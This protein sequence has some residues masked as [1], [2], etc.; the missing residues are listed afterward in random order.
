M[1]IR[2]PA[3]WERQSA[4]LL[5]WPHPD[6]DWSTLLHEV[7]PVFVEITRHASRH[8]TVIIACHND[9]HLHHI[10]ELLAGQSVPANRYRLFI[11]PSND[12]WA[13]DHGPVSVLINHRPQLL[14]FIFNG[15][16]GKFTADLDNRITTL[17][18]EA[19]A[20][21]DTPL[22]TI[23]LV[24]EGGS[25]E[26]DGS[27]TLL[28]TTSCLL[29]PRRNRGLSRSAIEDRLR[30]HLGVQRILWLEHGHLR[31]DDTDGH[32]DTLARFADPETMLYVSSTDPAD[33]NHDS[34]R[35]MAEELMKMVQSNGNPYRLMPL[36]SPVLRDSGGKYLPASYA[37]FVILNDAV[38]VPTYGIDMDGKALEI[39]RRCF[40]GRN[41]T[42]INCRPLIQQYGSLHCVT[43]QLPA[44]IVP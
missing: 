41:I 33:P 27:G 44:G 10:R 36:P 14:N 12:S 1:T 30:Q 38:L 8:Q 26:S 35:H 43:M 25:I 7:E 9:R 34:L 19:G 42:G 20:F 23:D 16:G 37:N 4:L 40:A 24:L 3:E 29:S 11:A 28:T 6:T 5:T 15:W 13:R 22:Q 21:G 32:I 31:G 18:H 17:L 39:F 2:L